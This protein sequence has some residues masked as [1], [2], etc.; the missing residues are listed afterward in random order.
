MALAVALGQV[1][2]RGEN[3]AIRVNTLLGPQ[4]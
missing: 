4:G 1:E 2:P 3:P